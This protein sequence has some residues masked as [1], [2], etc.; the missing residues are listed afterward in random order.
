MGPESSSQGCCHNQLQTDH[1]IAWRTRCGPPP[2]YPVLCRTPGLRWWCS[3]QCRSLEASR[4]RHRRRR[5]ST[6]RWWRRGRKAWGTAGSSR[7]RW[8]TWRR[9]RGRWRRDQGCWSNPLQL[10][11]RTD[12]SCSSRISGSDP[13]HSIAGQKRRGTG[14][15]GSSRR[16]GSA[17]SRSSNPM[18][19]VRP[20]QRAIPRLF[21]ET[22]AP[23][24][25]RSLSFEWLCLRCCRS[26][27]KPWRRRW[28]HRRCRS[29][30][31]G[32]L[33]RCDVWA[34]G[35]RWPWVSERWDQTEPAVPRTGSG[36]PCRSSRRW[37]RTT[38]TDCNRDP[39][40]TA[41]PPLGF[42]TALPSFLPLT[43]STPPLLRSISSY[44]S[45]F[46]SV[47]FIS[48][49]SLSI[50]L[51]TPSPPLL[52]HHTHIFY[53]FIQTLQLRHIHNFTFHKS[54]FQISISIFFSFHLIQDA[55]ADNSLLQGNNLSMRQK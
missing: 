48:L 14:G 38:R 24:R 10:H 2:C 55:Y 17:L 18:R 23:R 6:E 45:S 49:P 52:N 47:F 44:S 36:N 11:F 51:Y 35:R 7:T 19:M 20:V 15:L 28:R 30:W 26:W 34:S 41:H 40:D 54:L 12:R 16:L 22:F 5:E 31:L 39:L 13:C 32:R 29:L 50:Y 9:R 53:Y 33:R 25:P 21:R 43:P 8:R 1:S 42:H 37:S 46:L 3:S 27:G 4:R